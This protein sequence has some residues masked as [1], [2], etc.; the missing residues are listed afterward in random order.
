[1]QNIQNNVLKSCQKMFW[2]KKNHCNKL[3]KS[4]CVNTKFHICWT[5]NLFSFH[6]QIFQDTF[7][8]T[9]E[10]AY[11]QCT[12]QSNT[13]HLSSSWFLKSFKQIVIE[14][15]NTEENYFSLRRSFDFCP[16][17]WNSLLLYN[18]CVICI[19]LK[20]FC[21]WQSPIWLLNKCH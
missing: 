3:T 20:S 4:L 19:Y 10:K 15:I 18:L 13:S 17:K 16:W 14:K 1:M 6:V 12:G 11:Y 8:T 5:I 9:T 7:W 2:K 21:H